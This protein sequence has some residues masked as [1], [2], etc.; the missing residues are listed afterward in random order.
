[1]FNIIIFYYIIYFIIITKK[2]NNNTIIITQHQ[3]KNNTIKIKAT[4]SATINTTILY[5]HREHLVSIPN[6]AL[7]IESDKRI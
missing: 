6:S 1:M 7:P 5:S 4:T 3:K 2:N